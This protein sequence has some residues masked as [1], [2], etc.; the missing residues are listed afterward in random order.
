MPEWGCRTGALTLC[1]LRWAATGAWAPL[2]NRVIGNFRNAG[3]RRN[4]GDIAPCQFKI[5][6]TGADVP[7]HYRILSNFMV[8]R[9]RLEINLLQ[10][11]D[12]KI[13]NGFR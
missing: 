6:E 2:H 10:L 13:R 8:Y 5:G 3:Q 7:F 11:F 12:K 1:P 9:D 4:D